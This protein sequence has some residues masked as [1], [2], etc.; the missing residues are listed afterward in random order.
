MILVGLLAVL[1]LVGCSA[2]AGP[3]IGSFTATGSMVGDRESS[4]ATLLTDGRVLIAG[5]A[6]FPASLASAELYDPT[7]GKFAPTGSMTVPRG[8]G[9]ATSLSDGR[10]LVAGG[11]SDVDVLAS[12]ELYDPNTGTFTAT[13]SMS[14][15]REGHTATLL[16]DGR[17]LIAG[18]SNGGN[19]PRADVNSAELFDPKT[20]EFTPTGSLS[21]PRSFHSATRL[22]DGEVLLVGGGNGTSADLYDPASSMF[23]ATGPMSSPRFGATASRLLDGDVLVAGGGSSGDGQA[24]AELYN[25]T[26]RKFTLT[27]SMSTAR[28]GATAAVLADG[29]V[30]IVGGGERRGD[31]PDIDLS[32]AEVYDPGTG[33]F[34]S[35]GSM[36]AGRYFHTETALRD[37]SVL[38]AGGEWDAA[39]RSAELF[40]P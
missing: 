7:T 9:T 27:G 8:A 2:S 17:V 38:I 14:V 28:A 24:S 34:L 35:A 12:A 15:G 5:G 29:R 26:S 30:L 36:T 22:A 33:K 4:T 37:G 19:G 6:G 11:E 21:I 3:A 20:G 32:S 13:G 39:A 1:D 23:S 31:S 16:E 10:V 25:P 40:R 18:G